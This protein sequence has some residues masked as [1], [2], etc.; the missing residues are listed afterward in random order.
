MG[1]IADLL[2]VSMNKIK[3][4]IDANTIIGTP[5]VE[6]STIIIPVSRLQDRK[7]TRLNSSH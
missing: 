5:I 1:N 6:G 4:M 3:E 7:S 2:S